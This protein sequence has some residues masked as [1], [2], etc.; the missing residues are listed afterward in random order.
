MKR[1]EKGFLSDLNWGQLNLV[2]LLLAGIVLA[3]AIDIVAGSIPVLFGLTKPQALMIGVALALVPIGYFTLRFLGKRERTRTFSG[4]LV[5][6]IG[7]NEV[8]EVP[9]YHFSS[10][11]R[12]YLLNG[13]A[14]NPRLRELW[15][16]DQRQESELGILES[17][18]LKLMTE[19][20]VCYVLFELS[21]H[22][23]GYFTRGEFEGEKLRE[24]KRK[25]LSDIT[26]VNRFLDLFSMPL[27]RRSPKH[28][29]HYAPFVLKLPDRSTIRGQTEPGFE[30]ETKRMRMK[31]SVTLGVHKTD[32]PTDFR[33][34]YLGLDEMTKSKTHT[35]EI[36]LDVSVSFKLRAF[37]SVTGWNYYRWMDSFLSELDGKFSET[38]FFERI[39]WEKASIVIE[40][41][42]KYAQRE[43]RRLRALKERRE[44]YLETATLTNWLL[45]Y[46]Q[47]HED[48]NGVTNDL[49]SLNLSD[50]SEEPRRI[51]FLSRSEWNA[52]EKPG[53]SL[54]ELPRIQVDWDTILLYDKK[55]RTD[56]EIDH[57]LINDREL[58]GQSIWDAPTLYLDSVSGSVG[59]GTIRLG[60]KICRYY[61]N[62][63][64]MIKLEN[65]TIE[66]VR[67]DLFDNCPIRERYFLRVGDIEDNLY[68]PMTLG[69]MVVFALKAEDG[70]D[71]I[72]QVRS[73]KNATANSVVSI[74]PTYG[75]SP[76]LED[77]PEYKGLLFYNFLKEYL[78]EF[79]NRKE[80]VRPFH[81]FHSRG[82]HK[83]YYDSIYGSPEVQ[84]LLGDNFNLYYLGFGFNLINGFPNIGLL[85]KLDS[86]NDSR[87]I[88]EK[89]DP[90]WEIASNSEL[91]NRERGINFIN[92][93]KDADRLKEL[94]LRIEPA[95]AFFLASAL[96]YLG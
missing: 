60:V 46:H 11:V 52:P 43:Q 88:K 81:S 95:G 55:S 40:S 6:H 86:E 14:E 34:M 23:N 47:H 78:E 62:A 64:R 65:E 41:T 16:Q 7:N 39:G 51:P 67:L 27:D 8:V 71:I 9:Q 37:F 12:E 80:L 94:F 72:L 68:K 20:A 44:I 77:P 33:R 63:T 4:F 10:K 92:S 87:F 13:L 73:N 15:D 2:E 90:N 38:A 19:A 25:D 58:I 83:R 22:L 56:F 49:W 66:G 96:G 42:T 82:T 5:Y 35:L 31:I 74:A 75:L 17:E 18:K 53:K 26:E 91:N 1:D 79:F 69:C 61:A 36:S 57:D 76:F 21:Q 48:N 30:I 50:L 32:L 85:A 84:P 93:S 29:T 59:E 24:Y 45:E 89:I 70:Y 3:V 54:S 28:G